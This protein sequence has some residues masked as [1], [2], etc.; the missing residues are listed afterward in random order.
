[1]IKQERKF[2]WRL[3]ARNRRHLLFA[4]GIVVCTVLLILKALFP[5]AQAVLEANQ[6]LVK[7]GQTTKQLE[8]KL[9]R[10]E[11]L[12][13]SVFLEKQELVNGILPS[14]KP[15]LELLTGLNVV[16]AK[17]GVRFS[18]FQVSPGLIASS[19]AETAK[20]SGDKKGS[21]KDKNYDALVVQVTIEGSFN[22]VQNFLRE[23][24]R[25]APLTTVTDLDL[26]IRR[27]DNSGI[28]QADDPA[29]A[30]LKLDTYYYT[31]SLSAALTAPL[32]PMTATH[33]ELVE[34]LQEF[35]FPTRQQQEQILEGDIY[36]L[37]G[38]TGAEIREI[39]R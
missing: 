27:E 4:V 2:N 31:Q 25:L 9:R 20:T 28:V 11:E 24:E 19:S 14:K 18:D 36:D 1:M 16:A 32:P 26:S 23:V 22:Q 34:Q 7:K 10:L 38:I 13:N 35:T 15:V 30:E 39:E 21:T 17:A 37:F 33:D 3:F 29:S 6:Q 8:E 12:D 5:L